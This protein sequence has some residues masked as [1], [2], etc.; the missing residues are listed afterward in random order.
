MVPDVDTIVVA[1]DDFEVTV[2]VDIGQGRCTERIRR[3]RPAFH[4]RSI[5]MPDITDTD[6]FRPAVPV[7][8]PDGRTAGDALLCFLEPSLH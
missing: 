2:Q 7:E 6:D 3:L 8:V 1:E 5:M 4:G